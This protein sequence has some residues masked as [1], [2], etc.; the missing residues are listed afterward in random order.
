MRITPEAGSVKTNTFRMVPLH[1]HLI[2]QGF[3]DFVKAN[4]TGPLFYNPEAKGTD[5]DSDATSPRRPRAVKARERLAAWV[6]ELGVTDI[7]IRPNH[8]WRHTFKQIA[9]RSGISER[10][11]D[12]I[13]GH[14]P[15]T[16]GRGYGR[17]TVE[18]MAEALKKFPRYKT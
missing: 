9:E 6:R 3:L 1:E 16:A 8:A 7:G 18:D 15:T 12:A 17:P 14:A 5:K 13:T 11:S 2:E 10:V 4:G